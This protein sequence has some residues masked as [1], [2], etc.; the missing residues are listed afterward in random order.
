M[1][2]PS[3]PPAEINVWVIEDDLDY[4]RTIAF[5]LGHTTG[6]RC[7]QDFGSCEEAL[8]LLADYHG[9]PTPWARP[10]VLLLDINLPGASGLAALHA[11]KEALPLTRVVMLTIRDEAETIYAALRRGASGYLLKDAS[12]D[13]I[14][15]AV[16]EAYHGGTL[17]PA[18]VAQKVLRYFHEDTQPDYGLTAR[19]QEV[20]EEM[21]KGYTQKEIAQRLFVSR[22]TVNTHIQHIYEKLHV[23]S[24]IEAVSKALR[25]RLV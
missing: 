11:L 20:L 18:A 16:R 23:R 22:H 7:G 13:Q 2:V 6:I 24:G 8:A 4:R 5:L 21:V 10:D 3:T 15:A 9:H 19:E 14:V 1:A 17:M 25:E 12:V